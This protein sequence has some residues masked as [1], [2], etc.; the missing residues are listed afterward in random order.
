MDPEKIFKIKAKCKYFI[1]PFP[2]Q[3]NILF[4]FLAEAKYALNY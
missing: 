1:G 3:F 4:D 2:E